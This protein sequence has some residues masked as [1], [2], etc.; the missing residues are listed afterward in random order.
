ML[1]FK[2]ILMHYPFVSQR[3]DSVY[4]T[5]ITS[6]DSTQLILSMC[7][8]IRFLQITK[9]NFRFF[10]FVWYLNNLFLCS[11]KPKKEKKCQTLQQEL[12]LS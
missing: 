6:K 4:T 11:L 8:F 5:K 9:I 3:P 2:P 7:L 10:F 12:K 1:I